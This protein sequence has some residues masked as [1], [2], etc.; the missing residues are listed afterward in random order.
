MPRLECHIKPLRTLPVGLKS[1]V[2]IKVPY[3][4]R[5]CCIWGRASR[6]PDDNRRLNIVSFS[7]TRFVYLLCINP[8]A[9]NQMCLPSPPKI[10]HVPKGLYRILEGG[11]DVVD[12]PHHGIQGGCIRRGGIGPRCACDKHDG[13]CAQPSL[14]WTVNGRGYDPSG[15]HHDCRDRGVLGEYPGLQRKHLGG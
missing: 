6:T 7:A 10:D 8:D 1:R 12:T 3:L 5:T 9:F 13:Q 2:P 11:L 4:L 15:P 14:R